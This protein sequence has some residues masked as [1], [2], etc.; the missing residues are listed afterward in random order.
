[1]GPDVIGQGQMSSERESPK[2][3]PPQL[4]LQFHEIW[5]RWSMALALEQL[6]TYGPHGG[7]TPEASQT[8]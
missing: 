8:W 7:H 1:M 5:R 2:E 6:D 4:A 3:L